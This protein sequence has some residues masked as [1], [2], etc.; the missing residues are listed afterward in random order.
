MT[1][2]P[3]QVANMID[4]ICDRCGNVL[5]CRADH[6][7]DLEVVWPLLTDQG[8]A[9]SP[10][11]TGQHTCP[12]CVVG[13]LRE[14]R[15]AA[16]AAWPVRKHIPRSVELRHDPHAAIVEVRGDIDRLLVSTMQA[17]LG[18]AAALHRNIALDMSAVQLV[19]PI[20]LGVLVR[21]HV[22]ARKRGGHLCLAAPSRF[23]LTV[24]HTMRLDDALPVFDDLPSAL[25]WL[26]AHP[27]APRQAPAQR[28]S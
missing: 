12:G 16:A 5:S 14:S 7:R 18:R 27:P 11:A 8:W 21:G 26:A 2:V 9:G 6:L 13:Q 15:S 20:G 19:D 28:S 24:L 22:R 3:G 25:T 17:A 23:V 4:L 10:F 1:A